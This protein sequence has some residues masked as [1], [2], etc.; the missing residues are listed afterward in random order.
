MLSQSKNKIIKLSNENPNKIPNFHWVIFPYGA[1]VSDQFRMYVDTAWHRS[2][3]GTDFQENIKPGISTFPSKFRRIPH[4]AEPECSTLTPYL[5]KWFHDTFTIMV[6]VWLETTYKISSNSKCL[7][8]NQN[9]PHF[10]Y[11]S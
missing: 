3:T 5:S 4:T 2:L 8:H 7:D 9:F 6:V 10:T 11:V 1:C